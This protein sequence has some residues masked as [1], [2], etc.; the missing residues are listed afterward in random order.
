MRKV[1]V[2][3]GK[4][5]QLRHHVFREVHAL[6]DR[7]AAGIMNVPEEIETVLREIRALPTKSAAA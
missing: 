6:Y 4:E 7:V 5:A 3:A 1:I 2:I